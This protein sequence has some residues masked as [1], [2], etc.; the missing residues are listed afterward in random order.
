MLKAISVLDKSD[1]GQVYLLN[2]HSDEEFDDLI[3]MLNE[4]TYDMRDGKMNIA[5]LTTKY[6]DL[7]PPI[8]DGPQIEEEIS[9]I[10]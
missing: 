2:H 3:K 7:I 10:E 9:Q 4:I 8:E 1:A 5:D 6:I